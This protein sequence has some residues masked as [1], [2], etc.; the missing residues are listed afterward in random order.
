MLIRQRMLAITLAT[1]LFAS[2]AIA[3]DANQQREAA[4]Q[5]AKE[6]ARQQRLLQIEA[7]QRRQAQQRQQAATADAGTAKPPVVDAG[8]TPTTPVVDA[9]A[10]PVVDAGKPA[11]A[12]VSDAG[13]RDGSAPKT[14]AAA[15]ATADDKL[16]LPPT[17]L[18]E[19]IR[20]RPD[21]RKSSIERNQ[22]RW[23]ELLSDEK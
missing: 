13:V 20:T 10:K 7:E 15:A 4:R 14:D 9:G 5:K 6:D 1:T 11:D 18:E 19:L 21:R 8:T 16:S 17:D 12:G 23:G 3:Q 2:G 22:R